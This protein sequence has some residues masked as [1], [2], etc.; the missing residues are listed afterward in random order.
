MFYLIRNF[1]DV[2]YDHKDDVSEVCLGH[3][4]T[5]VIDLFFENS[6]WQKY[7]M[8]YYFYKFFRQKCFAD[9]SRRLWKL[10]ELLYTKDKV[11]FNT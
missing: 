10:T 5:S 8:T 3:S 11:L 1:L 6:S 4:Q 7:L 2:A 9:S